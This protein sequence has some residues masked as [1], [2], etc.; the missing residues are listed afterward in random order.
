M[1]KIL[2]ASCKPGGLGDVLSSCRG[3]VGGEGFGCR[4]RMVGR[5]LV[6]GRARVWEGRGGGFGD[7]G[8]GSDG[9]AEEGGE[10]EGSGGHCVKVL[11]V[12]MGRVVRKDGGVWI[13]LRDPKP[14][15]ERVITGNAGIQSINLHTVHLSSDILSKANNLPN[16]ESIVS[17]KPHPV[18]TPCHPL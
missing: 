4:G 15:D 6:G 14:L 1:Q 17:Y 9:V 13:A 16:H 18:A 7:C 10:E 3:V 5:R 2:L 11:V 12:E 8:V